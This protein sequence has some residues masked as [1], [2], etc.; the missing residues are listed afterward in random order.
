[1]ASTSPPF[2]RPAAKG[3]HQRFLLLLLVITIVSI[4]IIIII[5]SSSSIS[6]TLGA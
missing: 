5:G 3:E 1:V 2:Y 6:I 4:I